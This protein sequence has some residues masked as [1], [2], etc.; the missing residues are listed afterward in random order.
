MVCNLFAVALTCACATQKFSVVAKLQ[1]KYVQSRKKFM[2]KF[3]NQLKMLI[4]AAKIQS[5][6]PHRHQ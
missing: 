5:R 2:K 6:Q 4:F 1:N 3:C